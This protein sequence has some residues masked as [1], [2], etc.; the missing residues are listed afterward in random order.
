M[1]DEIRTGRIRLRPLTADDRAEFIR[2]HSLNEAHFRPWFPAQDG[3]LEDLF[4]RELAKIARPEVHVRWVGEATNGSLVG[5][6]NLG[7]IVRGVFQ[8]AYASWATSVEVAGQGYATE[9]VQ[10]LLDLAFS[11]VHGL[12]LHRVQANIMPENERSLRLA[13]RLGM[14]REGIAE[15]YLKIAGEWRDHVTFAKTT[16]EH[17]RRYL[18]S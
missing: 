9:G 10:A 4:E 18:I 2:V 16:E 12:Q 6:F 13:E 3:S 15:R 11:E 5:F 8:N 7:E 17:T 14:R 1:T